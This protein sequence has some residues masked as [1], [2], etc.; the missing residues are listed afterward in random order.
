M[1]RHAGEPAS[2]A[3]LR[4]VEAWFISL[5]CMPLA[6]RKLIGARHSTQADHMPSACCQAA[7][8]HRDLARLR[9]HTLS[10]SAM[11]RRWWVSCR[12]YASSAGSSGRPRQSASWCA[13]FT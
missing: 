11:Y 12:A 5:Y 2:G 4:A 10:R 6:T 7:N 1:K 13:L 9:V 8:E 3:S